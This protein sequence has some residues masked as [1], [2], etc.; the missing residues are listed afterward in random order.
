LVYPRY[1]SRTAVSAQGGA[2]GEL[3]ARVPACSQMS[4]DRLA[5]RLGLPSGTNLGDRRHALLA[6]VGPGRAPS[7]PGN[8]T[9]ETGASTATTAGGEPP[10]PV[11]CL[12]HFSP[13]TTEARPV[14]GP[15]LIVGVG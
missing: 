2:D 1:V 12:R 5:W 10:V 9:S 6:D 7:N 14:A 13:E 8:P 15:G 4:A 11:S 3:G